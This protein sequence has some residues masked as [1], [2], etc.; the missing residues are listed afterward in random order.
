[1]TCDLKNIISFNVNDDEYSFLTTEQG[2]NA[3]VVRVINAVAGS[4]LEIMYG[5]EC[6]EII[7][8]ENTIE[9]DIE[10]PRKYCSDGAIVHFRY[11]DSEKTTGF[12]HIVGDQSLYGNLVLVKKNNDLYF[13]D[14]TLAEGVEI[15]YL[16]K[17]ANL[18]SEITKVNVKS[19]YNNLFVIETELNRQLTRLGGS[20]GTTVD[21]SVS[22]LADIEITPP[23]PPSPQ[24]KGQIVAEVLIDG[25]II[26][27]RKVNCTSE[28]E[29]KEG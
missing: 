13:C 1:M 17:L 24:G 15:D 16:K 29:V 26:T 3:I 7:P 11:V 5:S 19:C 2:N 12:I 8:L 21:E 4:T 14:G 27:T 18:I 25:G 6:K 9:Q 22:N 10:I 23:S 28:V 20:I